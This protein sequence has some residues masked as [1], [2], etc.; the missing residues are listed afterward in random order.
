MSFKTWTNRRWIRTKYTY[1][2]EEKNV[3]WNEYERNVERITARAETQAADSQTVKGDLT[4]TLPTIYLGGGGTDTLSGTTGWT[5][6]TPAIEDT[7]GGNMR[8]TVTWERP[9]SWTVKA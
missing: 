5:V 2:Y 1:A 7:G 9:E 4:S 6:K 3:W 8:V